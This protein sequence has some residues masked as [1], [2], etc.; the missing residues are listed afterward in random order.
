MYIT[1]NNNRNMSRNSFQ[2]TN[3]PAV[4]EFSLK[5]VLFPEL[6][7]LPDNND[8]DSSDTSS[9]NII[10]YKS[11]LL[12]QVPENFI[13][14]VRIKEKTEYELEIEKKRAYHNEAC[15]VIDEMSKK[16]LN[17]RLNYIEMWGEDEYERWY[18]P[19]SDW[20]KAIIGEEDD[21]DDDYES[22]EDEENCDY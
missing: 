14:V 10:N 2:R 5:S 21:D 18:I 16:W 15:K 19:L 12:T 17:F 4:E 11:I 9:I 13:P 22:T 6:P 20:D 7:E 3:K 8:K 1:S